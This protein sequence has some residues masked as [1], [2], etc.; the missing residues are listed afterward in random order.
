MNPSIV[1]RLGIFGSSDADTLTVVRQA[2]ALS[3]YSLT[4]LLL[5]PCNDPRS[6]GYPGFGFWGL[7]FSGLRFTVE[8]FRV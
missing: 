8:D 6:P 1:H 3:E 4:P 7:E 2:D 5:E